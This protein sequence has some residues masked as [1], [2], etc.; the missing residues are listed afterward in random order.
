MKKGVLLIIMLS[1]TLF[2]TLGAQP[3]YTNDLKVTLLSQTPDPAEPGQIVTLKFQIENDGPELQEDAIIRILPQYPFTI[4]SGSSEQNVGKLRAAGSGADAAIVTYKLKVDEAAAEGDTELELEVIT[5]DT[6]LQFTDNEFLINIQTHDAILDIRNI[7]IE[8]SSVTP[9]QTAQVT[10][11]VK[12]LADS[13][14]KDIQYSLNLTDSSLPFAPYKSSSSRQISSL[15]TGY[16]NTFTFNLQISPQATSGFYK[17]PLT[18]SYNDEQGKSYTSKDV[19][20]LTISEAPKLVPYIKKSTLLQSGS[21][22]IVTLEIANAGTSDL[23]YLELIVDSSPD[24]TLLSS[25]N[26]FYIGDV[27]ADDTESEDISLYASKDLKELLLPI[28][29][30]YRDA[31]NQEY[32]QDFQLTLPLYSSS[33]LKQFGL[34]ESSSIGII[35]VLIL[36]GVGGYLYYRYAKKKKTRT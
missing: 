34:I 19:L 33:Q 9:G 21:Q 30:K 6:S 23:K 27:D 31:A 28:T 8:P 5:G 32:T 14:L 15:P 10:V 36:L 35:F 12:N 16:Q 20:A 7:E 1:L 17:I 25:S 18:I 29:L 22:G 4:Y 13:L 11:T 26:Y 24:Y 3:F 2:S